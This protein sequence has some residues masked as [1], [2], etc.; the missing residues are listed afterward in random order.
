[1]FLL[2]RKKFI[3]RNR[4]TFKSLGGHGST[5]NQKFFGNLL[6]ISLG[7][8]LIYLNISLGPPKNIMVVPKST[9]GYLPENL[10]I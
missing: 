8:F 1:M 4:K 10:R 3:R 9:V 5:N 2:H 7:G 6:K